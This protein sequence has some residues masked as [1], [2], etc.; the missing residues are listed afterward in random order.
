MNTPLSTPNPM[1]N[2]YF[3]HHM[4]ITDPFYDNSLSLDDQKP[5]YEEAFAELV[6]RKI[7]GLISLK[8][9]AE[10]YPLSKVTNS[11][12][13]L[14]AE[15]SISSPTTSS[16]SLV[17]PSTVYTDSI[18]TN[19]IS[20]IDTLSANST[21]VEID[22]SELVIEKNDLEI[23]INIKSSITISHNRQLSIKEQTQSKRFFKIAA[24]ACCSLFGLT[25]PTAYFMFHSDA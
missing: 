1:D 12:E 8:E 10:N 4:T 24:I 13:S 6:Q 9:H 2:P 14:E 20:E 25:I 19:S 16:D 11:N 7:Y 18:M 21:T 5:E 15:G 22:N 17:S 23:S 3:K